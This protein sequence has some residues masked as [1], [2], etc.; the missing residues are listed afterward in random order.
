MGT[1]Y[2]FVPNAHYNSEG[3]IREWFL[4]PGGKTSI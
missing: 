1:K 2:L 3:R 4:N